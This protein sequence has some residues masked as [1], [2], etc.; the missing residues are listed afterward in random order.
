MNA[1]TRTS[2]AVARQLLVV[3]QGLD[4]TDLATGAMVHLDHLAEQLGEPRALRP[5]AAGRAVVDQLVDALDVD[6]LRRA[7]V[8]VDR[9]SVAL[10][11]AWQNDAAATAM[12][13]DRRRPPADLTVLWLRD[14]AHAA[15]VQGR[16]GDAHRAELRRTDARI[17]EISQALGHD[18]VPVATTVCGAANLTP[19]GRTIDPCALLRRAL[20]RAAAARVDTRVALSHVRV[21][22]ESWPT[23]QRVA[24]ALAAIGDD[25]HVL[26]FDELAAH[27]LQTGPAEVLA[28]PAPGCAFAH[29][30]VRAAPRY[31]A[32]HTGPPCVLSPV[33][34]AAEL[35]P[36]AVGRALRAAARQLATAGAAARPADARRVDVHSAPDLLAA[37]APSEQPAQRQLR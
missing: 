27:G 33:L 28:I 4:R 29:A 35:T 19:V 10:R 17:R 36:A 5:V 30:P 14:A 3:V 1:A 16:H 7:R 2:G 13:L 11:A 9:R 22:C 34:D 8:S 23:A 24:A 26:S 15:V 20:G 37:M 6:G 18:G 31:L 12:L 25:V 32:D 21:H